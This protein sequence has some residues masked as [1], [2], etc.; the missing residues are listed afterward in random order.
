MG[1]NATS[2]VFERFPLVRNIVGVKNDSDIPYLMKPGGGETLYKLPSNLF[3]RGTVLKMQK[4]RKREHL[5]DLSP[6]EVVESQLL[7]RG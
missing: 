1:G 3:N 5:L 7:E 4:F 2:E 6:C